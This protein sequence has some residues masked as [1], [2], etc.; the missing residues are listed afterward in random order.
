MNRSKLPEDTPP[1]WP[2]KYVDISS[3][4]GNGTAPE[5]QELVFGEAPSR[6]RM[7]V[8]AGDTI[9]ST[10][11]TYLRAVAHFDEPDPNLICSTGF[12]VLS[13]AKD[14]SPRFLYYWVRSDWFVDVVVARSVGVSYP[15][16][17]PS[18]LA[19][20][21]VPMPTTSEQRAVADFLD[22]ETGRIDALVE[23][24]R[25]LIELLEEK[26]TALISHVVTKGLDPTV[27]MKDSGIPWLGEIPAH[28]ET[29]RLRHISPKVTVGV[30]VNPSHYFSDEGSIAFIHGKDV[31]PGRILTG[32]LKR[33]TEDSNQV[34]RKSMVRSG[35]LLTVR[36]GEPGV[37][38]MVP[39]ELDGSNCAS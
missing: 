38:A 13:P 7:I 17:R 24:K 19:S 28:W 1:D 11:R 29:R 27:P 22:R 39:E 14:L 9:I 5:T 25:R 36:V 20:M 12:A 37:T 3:V 32:D 34:L 15:A 35:D 33:I 10:V 18:E 4:D 31:R 16:V 6:A 21:P 8:K 26:R 23:K 2:L 30:V